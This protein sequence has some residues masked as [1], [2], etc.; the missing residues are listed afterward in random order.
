ME[1]MSFEGK[2]SGNSLPLSSRIS[3]IDTLRGLCVFL[4]FLYHFGYD[5]YFYCGFPAWVIQNPVFTA[6]QVW[7]S[8][9][10]IFLAG[11][12]C[13]LSRSNWKRGA[14][15]L[16]LGGVVS[17]V[18]WFWGDFVRFGILHFMGCSMLIYGLTHRLWEKLPRWPAIVL[19]VGLFALARQRMPMVLDIPYLYPFGIIAPGFR[20]SDYF[21]L[22]PWFFLF[23]AGSWAGEWK[24]RLPLWICRL[25]VPVFN[26]LGR[27]ALPAYL[28]HQPVLVV[29]AM[30]LAMLTGRQFGVT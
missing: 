27:H 30:G 5:L 22:L 15:V 16:L 11:L 6:V 23:L 14:R 26:W 7:G 29:I 3:G 28:V 21:P 8:S 9:T 10:F 24:D 12:S 17:V 19:Y 1:Y 20:S 13:R 18:T 4:M 25:K 2:E